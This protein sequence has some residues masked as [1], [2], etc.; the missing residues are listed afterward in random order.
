MKEDRLRHDA[1]EIHNLDDLID[2]RSENPSHTARDSDSLAD[3]VEIP[4]S[5]DVNNALTF[6]HP[7]HKA[8]ETPELMGEPYDVDMDE[9]WDAQD[10]QPSDYEHAYDE[11][12]DA[13]LTDDPDQVAGEQVHEMGIVEVSE[14]TGKPTTEIMPSRFEPDEE[15][16]T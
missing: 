8:I 15:S 14:L 5:L 11:A 16:Q 6:P 3:D 1:A 13:H 2:A 4:D 9:D 7:K 12:T 10:A